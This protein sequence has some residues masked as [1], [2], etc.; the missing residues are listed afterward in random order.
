MPFY[1][2]RQYFQQGKAE[3]LARLFALFEQVEIPFPAHSGSSHVT[4]YYININLP[5]S[6]DYNRAQYAF[7]YIRTVVALLALKNKTVFFKNTFKDL[8]FYGN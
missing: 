5:V 3:G 2:G 1:F 8:P 4:F 7:F 6:R